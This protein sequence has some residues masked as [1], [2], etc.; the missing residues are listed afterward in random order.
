MNWIFLVLAGLMEV[1]F[2]F[3]LG[4]TKTAIGTDIHRRA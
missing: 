2:T 3:C 4:K 1:A